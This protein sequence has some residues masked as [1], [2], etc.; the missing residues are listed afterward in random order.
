MSLSM[1]WR[2]LA[3]LC[4]ALLLSACSEPA[5]AYAPDWSPAEDGPVPAKL[6]R[7][8]LHP[9]AQGHSDGCEEVMHPCRW[10][11]ACTAPCARGM[12]ACCEG[13]WVCP[14]G[15]GGAVAHVGKVARDGQRE[16][17]RKPSAPS[18]RPHPTPMSSSSRGAPE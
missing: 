6:D 9:F 13:Q 14:A 3:P 1:T 18:P 7:I 11:E 15:F 10:E 5:P 16:P 17:R 4:A 8:P 12:K 2:R